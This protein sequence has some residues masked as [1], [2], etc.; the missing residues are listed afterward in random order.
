MNRHP[1]SFVD[2]ADL[3]DG[4]LTEEAQRRVEAHLAAG[5]STCQQEL[6]WLQ[7]VIETART[8]DMVEPPAESVAKAKLLYR[9]RVA[10]PALLVRLKALFGLP[11]LSRAAS[12]AFVLAV[13]VMLVLTQVPT[14]FSGQARLTALDGVA[15]VRAGGDSEWRQVAPGIHLV[16]GDQL[17]LVDGTAVLALFDGSMLHMEP[18]TVL[19]LSVLRSGL[20]G[21]SHRVVLDQRLGSVDYDVA[22]LRSPISSFE[23]RSP[24]VR[25]MV[26]GTR[27]VVTVEKETETRVSVLE[28]SVHLSSPVQS[29]VLFEREVAVVPLDASLVRLPTLLPTPTSVSGSTAEGQPT[30]TESATVTSSR[31][32]V[33]PADTAVPPTAP[34]APTLGTHPTRRAPQ[35]T[36]PS[37]KATLPVTPTLRVTGTPPVAEEPTPTTTLIGR[38]EQFVGVIERFPPALRGVWR[39]GERNVL[40]TRDTE[41]VGTPAPGLLATVTYSLSRPS[42]AATSIY[43]VLVAARIEIEEPSSVQPG[44]PTLTLVSP[45]LTRTP[46]P[47]LTPGETVTAAPTIVEPGTPT[48]RPT[49]MPRLTRTPRPT[50]TPEL[51]PTPSPTATPAPSSTLLPVTAP[52]PQ[53]ITFGGTIERL[54]AGLL[55]QWLIGGREVAVTPQT[56]IAGMPAVGL[57]AEVEAVAAPDTLHARRIVIYN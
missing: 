1:V 56:A 2:L 35:A 8:D 9:S 50:R 31:T 36:V 40:V 47:F 23:A 22:A 29:T 19:T 48:E 43:A 3:L 53:V 26:R 33:E 20:L 18:N 34:V 44:Q 37:A 14:L 54:P 42:P 41:I 28:G 5:C 4:Q 21:G 38:T 30:P 25:V 24:T 12:L 27:F 17:H 11:N 55:G 16:E 10:P 7:R 45:F 51:S 39:I 15:Q 49:R 52:G 46:E 57:H 13:S 6:A 32:A